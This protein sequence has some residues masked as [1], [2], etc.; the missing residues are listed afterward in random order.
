MTRQFGRSRANGASVYEVD[1]LSVE[2]EDGPSSK[3]GD[4]IAARFSVPGW[5]RPAVVV[6]DAGFRA[7]GEAMCEHITTYY[8][9]DIIDLVISTH[10]DTDHI[11]GLPVVL[12]NM[13]VVNLL[14][15]QPRQ[16]AGKAAKDFRNIE[17]VDD[18]LTIAKRK[19]TTVAQPFA[20]AMYFGT[21]LRI[22]G[23]TEAYYKELV[24]AHLD[25]VRSGSASASK[26]TSETLLAKFLRKRSSGSVALLPKE[27]LTDDGETG[28]RN[29]MSVITLVQVDGHRILFTGDA[30]IPALTQAADAYEAQ[31]GSF[32]TVGIDLF[33]APH[34]GSHHNVG[35][36]ILDRILG[37]SGAGYQEVSA[38]ISSAK[39][40]EDHPSPKV[41]NALLRRGCEVVATEGHGKQWSSSDAPSRPGWAPVTPMGPQAEN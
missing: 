34:H 7:A 20:G 30:G 6:I 16:Y 24:E 14:V 36:T 26:G 27:T 41:V 37:Q 3:S 19:G 15:H 39:A 29:N 40:D 28:P 13:S 10:P 38:M 9:T 1:L 33:Q 25:E 31:I 23:P 35:R 32:S 22:L 5:S 18:L 12:E 17:V 21:Q 2:A 4:A 11:N 8:K